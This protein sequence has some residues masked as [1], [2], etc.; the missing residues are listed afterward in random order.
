LK[1]N[2][3]SA[4]FGKAASL[5]GEIHVA[6]NVTTRH[7]AQ[8]EIFVSVIVSSMRRG[9]WGIELEKSH[10]GT[11]PLA[12]SSPYMS[13]AMVVSRQLVTGV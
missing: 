7:R 11:A 3:L 1:P 5:L 6:P 10:A 12:S 8:N 13:S 4:T 9:N 2:V